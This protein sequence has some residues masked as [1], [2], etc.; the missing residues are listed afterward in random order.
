MYYVIYSVTYIRAGVSRRGIIISICAERSDVAEL[1]AKHANAHSSE[2]RFLIELLKTK[3][4]QKYQESRSHFLRQSSG[5]IKLTT[6]VSVP[7]L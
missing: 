3:K 4:N 6:G 1:N 5:E 7:F 2:M